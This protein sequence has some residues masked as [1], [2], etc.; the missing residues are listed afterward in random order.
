MSESL[1]CDDE[2]PFYLIAIGMLPSRTRQQR[3]IIEKKISFQNRFAGFLYQCHV[4]CLCV[5]IEHLSCPSRASSCRAWWYRRPCLRFFPCVGHGAERRPRLLITYL[6]F[7]SICGLRRKDIDNLRAP[8]FG[9]LGSIFK[10]SSAS[11]RGA[12]AVRSA[13][14]L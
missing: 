13:G 8:V 10:V 9:G 4:N 7:S 11:R 2:L 6:L 14:F 12:V 1:L 5:K 3:T